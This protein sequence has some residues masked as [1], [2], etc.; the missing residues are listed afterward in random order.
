MSG[1]VAHRAH[2]D[3]TAILQCEVWIDSRKAGERRC[4]RDALAGTRRCT[5][6]RTLPPDL[7]RCQHQL[8]TGQRCPRAIPS[9]RR[10][11]DDFC[12]LRHGRPCP[13]L[14]IVYKLVAYDGRPVAKFSGVKSTFPGPKQVWRPNEG[15]AADVLSV[16]DGQE[17]GQPL[18]RPV[19]RDGERVEEPADLQ[20]VRE[21]VED[22]L[23][24]LP[25]CWRIPPYVDQAPMPTSGAELAE[26]TEQVRRRAFGPL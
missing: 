11:R 10:G 13:G 15:I 21:R 4:Q 19:W 17:S 1:F 8:A 7:Y 5:I 26:L 20:T 18:L 2:P 24:A 9:G 22:G 14:D 23:A 16:R 3:G 6:H 25:E 12:H